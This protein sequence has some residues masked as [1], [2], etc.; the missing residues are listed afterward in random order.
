MK[1]QARLHRIVPVLALVLALAPAQVRAQA[2]G[3]SPGQ[4]VGERVTVEGSGAYWNITVDELRVMLERQDVPLVNVHVP[5]AGDIE[6][7]DLSIPFD[8]ITQHLDQLPA[9]KS[10]PVVLYCRSG[11]MSTTASTE[12]AKLGYTNVYNLLG[13][14]RA[15]SAAGLPMAPR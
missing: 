5:F 1:T 6:G 4:T 14:F 7:T 2:A 12:L 8:Q 10:A 3:A 15:W 9:D 11:N 13:G